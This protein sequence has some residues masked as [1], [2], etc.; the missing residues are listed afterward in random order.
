MNRAGLR[1]R[2]AR[3][4]LFFQRLAFEDV[5]GPRVAISAA[6]APDESAEIQ[7][8]FQGVAASLRSVAG[9]IPQ[10][11]KLVLFP[12][13]ALEPGEQVIGV[14]NREATRSFGQRSQNLLIGG[15][16][17][18]ERRDDCPRL[19]VRRV[20]EIVGSRIAPAA[21]T[22][23][24]APPRA[25]SGA[26]SC[27]SSSTGAALTTSP[28]TAACATSARSASTTTSS[29]APTAGT[30]ST[31][32]SAAAA[33]ATSPAGPAASAARPLRIGH[34]RG[35]GGKKNVWAG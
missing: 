26:P 14:E 21:R 32:T 27:A 28:S 22:A 17:R 5:C 33:T 9:H 35:K 10:D 31:W 12:P 25:A 15:Y 34:G 18:R 30:A 2:C 8:H 16:G 13:D 29:S 7:L 3:F 19:V 24:R 6:R 23:I 4:E 20:V 1:S 11:V